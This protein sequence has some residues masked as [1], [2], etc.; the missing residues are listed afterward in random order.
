MELQRQQPVRD[1]RA[2]TV[3]VLPDSAYLP[4][5]AIPE[6]HYIAPRQEVPGANLDRSISVKQRP[7]QKKKDALKQIREQ[8]EENHITNNQHLYQRQ[9]MVSKSTKKSGVLGSL[10]QCFGCAPDY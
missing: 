5:T 6:E 3:F 9:E 8:Y 7:P 2:S 4:P 1:C 10:G